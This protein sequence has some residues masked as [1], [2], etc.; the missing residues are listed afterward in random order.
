M[1][2]CSN[3]DPTYSVISVLPLRTPSFQ[4]MLRLQVPQLYNGVRHN[5]FVLSGLNISNEFMPSWEEEVLPCSGCG[6]PMS[7]L[8][9]GHFNTPAETIP[10]AKK[11]KL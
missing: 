9:L 2:H 6:I 5:G 10:S 8:T 7:Q 1:C 4:G 11:R 3:G